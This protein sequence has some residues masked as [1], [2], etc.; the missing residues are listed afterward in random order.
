MGGF[1]NEGGLQLV[2]GSIKNNQASASIVDR[3]SGIGEDVMFCV[4]LNNFEICYFW[5][6]ENET[7]NNKF[8]STVENFDI[9]MRSGALE[10]GGFKAFSWFWPWPRA[11][12]L[13]KVR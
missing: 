12:P 1:G 9:N 7:H 8:M 11:P 6:T 2:V 13:A 4:E 5:M 10:W 3:F